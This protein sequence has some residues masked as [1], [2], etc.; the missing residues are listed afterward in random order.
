MEH[1]YCGFKQ[2]NIN[3]FIYLKK[4]I[5]NKFTKDDP[6]TNPVNTL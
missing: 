6:I 3:V 4:T 5:I 1:S 2:M